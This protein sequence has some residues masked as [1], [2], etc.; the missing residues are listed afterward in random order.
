MKVVFIKKTDMYDNM[1]TENKIY[2]VFKIN[3]TNIKE[4]LIVNDK[5]NLFWIPEYYFTEIE[6]KRESKIDSLLN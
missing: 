1:M 4:F 3:H 5:G 6:K 2:K